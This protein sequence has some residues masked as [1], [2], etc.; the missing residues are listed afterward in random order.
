MSDE[1][2]I[3]NLEDSD[4]NEMLL[5]FNYYI[6]NNFAAYPENEVNSK[7]FLNIKQTALCFYVLELGTRIIGFAFLRNYL[8]YENFKQTGVLTYFIDHKYTNKGLGTL[9]LN[10]LIEYAK[11]HEIRILL[12]NLSSLNQQSLNFHKKHGFHECGRFKNIAK[13]F[14]KFFDVIWMQKNL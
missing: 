1:F 5:I 14:N 2:R 6:K 9:L 12:V 7:F 10:K 8:P 13:K 4:L 11:E 3:R